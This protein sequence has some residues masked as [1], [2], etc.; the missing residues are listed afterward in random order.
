MGD[1]KVWRQRFSMGGDKHISA[2]PL[3]RPFDYLK[4]ILAA[5]RRER[6]DS[7]FADTSQPM[8]SEDAMIIA[9]QLPAAHVSIATKLSCILARNSIHYVH[10]V[11]ICGP[12]FRDQKTPRQKVCSYSKNKAKRVQNFQKKICHD[13]IETP[14]KGLPVDTQQT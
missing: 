5:A 12:N 9:R 7:F 11:P 10:C 2:E 8:L 4:G 3:Q 13:G 6:H 14:H 1:E